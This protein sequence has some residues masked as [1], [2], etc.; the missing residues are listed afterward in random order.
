M[1]KESEDIYKYVFDCWQKVYEYRD[2]IENDS[3]IVNDYIKSVVKWFKDT[4]EYEIKTKK[5]DRIFRFLSLVNIAYDDK[6]YQQLELLPWQAYLV[7]MIFGMYI[8]GT[9]KRRFSES[10][11][12]MGRGNGKTT[13]GVAL[14]LYFLLG[15]KQISP[16]SIIISTVENRAKVIQDLHKTVMH[17]PELHQ[18]L[19]FNNG[20]VMLNSYDS[21]IKRGERPI[22]FVNDVGGIKVVPNDDKKIDGLELVLAFIDEIH[23]LKDEMVF[24][25]AQKSAAKRKDSLVM[26][27]STA[28]FKT[29]GF[30]VDLVDRAKKVAMGEIKDDKFL[31]FLFCLDKRDDPEDISNNILWHK[32]NPSLGHTKPLKRMEDFYNDAQFSPKAKADF[33]TKDLNIFIDYNEEEVL[34]VE[35]RIRAGQKVDLEKWLGQDC[36]LGLDLS[37]TNDLSS[38]VCLFHTEEDDKWEAYPYYWIGNESK[39][40][41]RKG[42]ENL[43]KWIKDGHITRCNDAYIDYKL[44]ADRIKELSDKYNIVGIGYDPYG[45]NEFR[46]YIEDVNCGEHYKVNQWTKYMAEPLSK[47][48]VAIISDKLIYSDNPVMTWN[49][50]NARI[51]SADANGNLKIFR[52]ESRDSQDGAIALNNA[53]A[54][55]FHK[56][57]DPNIQA[58]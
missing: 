58:F 21:N 45:W 15:Y 28:G 2:G 48:L 16:Q 7:A 3:I 24:R 10:F 54:L 51:R 27:I 40:L 43:T 42:G 44:I 46:R 31:P 25:N 13:L 20:A 34:S 33:K 35:H 4:P 53:M 6:G 12:Y 1:N 19:H 41:T 11:T 55:F 26:L 37:K 14:S 29:D 56:N 18:F 49:W 8:R 9:N 38:L 5:V 17:S 47:I 22:K 30:C 52:N 39:F 57:Y 50:K 23:L 32:C 36:Y